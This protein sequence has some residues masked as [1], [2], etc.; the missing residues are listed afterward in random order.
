MNIND[1]NIQKKLSENQKIFLNALSN[2][3]DDD[4]HLYG[5]IGRLD[6]IP[7]KS[8]LD[9]DIFTDN[10]ESLIYKLSNFLHV[11]KNVFKNVL[12]K[13]DNQ[14]IHGYKTKYENVKK[15]LSIEFS[16]YNKKDK[17]TIINQHGKA[18]KLPYIIL[19]LLYIIKICYYK[20]G[21]LNNEMYSKIKQYLMHMSSECNF[22]LL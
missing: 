17:E 19:F 10:E 3:I 21:I 1:T 13:I 5:S 15:N 4:L 12:Y 16:I 6:Y 9:L 2:Y 20:L 7:N 22:I 14:I 8:D 11:K 18:D